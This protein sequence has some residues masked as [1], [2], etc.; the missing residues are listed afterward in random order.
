M[1]GLACSI[2]EG[3]RVDVHDCVVTLTVEDLLNLVLA[4]VEQASDVD[5][6]G[7]CSYDASYYHA[8]RG[9]VSGVMSFLGHV[10]TALVA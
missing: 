1:I 5:E 4:C 2:C 8:L 3:K 9:G 6:A 10:R 7:N